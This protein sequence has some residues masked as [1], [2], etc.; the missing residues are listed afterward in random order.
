MYDTANNVQ[1]ESGQE[2]KLKRAIGFH[3]SLSGVLIPGFERYVVDSTGDV[4][5]LTKTSRSGK[6]TA[7]DLPRRLKKPRDSYGYEVVSLNSQHEKNRV[8]KVHRLVAEAFIPNPEGK[9]QVNHINGVKH[10]NRV[11]NL[12]W[13]TSSENITHSV[14]CLGNMPPEHWTGKKNPHLSQQVVVIQVATRSVSKYSSQ[15]ALA[16]SGLVSRSSI[17]KKIDTENPTKGLLIY[18]ASYV[19][20]YHAD[21]WLEAYGLEVAA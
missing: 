6:I 16:E 19:K 21:V 13:A 15:R 18:R 2:E 4:F 3:P 1:Q 5:L 7:L 10:D 14:H 17:Q 20:A 12:E 8:K 11:E 9:P